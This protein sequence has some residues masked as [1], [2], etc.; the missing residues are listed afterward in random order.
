MTSIHCRDVR[1]FFCFCF[2]S[3]ALSSYH[4]VFS[5]C[6]NCWLNFLSI[7]NCFTLAYRLLPRRTTKFESHQ[8]VERFSWFQCVAMIVCAHALAVPDIL[9]VNG[10]VIFICKA[11]TNP[12]ENPHTPPIVR[13]NQNH[14][15][16]K[17]S[18]PMILPNSPLHIINGINKM[19]AYTFT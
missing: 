8:S 19:H 16:N 12:M 13:A 1:E 3:L 10:D 15:S 5:Y 7:S 4:H 18:Y 14:S 2:C 9:C 6:N 11:V 17:C